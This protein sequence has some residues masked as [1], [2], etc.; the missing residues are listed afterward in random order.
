[1]DG[2]CH[3]TQLELVANNIIR[4]APYDPLLSP[5]TQIANVMDQQSFYSRLTLLL[6]VWT[7]MFGVPRTPI[8]K[9]PYKIAYESSIA[10]LHTLQT[11]VL[12]GHVPAVAGAV[13]ASDF[14]LRPNN[15]QKITL[16][17]GEGDVKLSWW[18]PLVE[19]QVAQTMP[20][21]TPQAKA[22]MIRGS[23]GPKVL[24]HMANQL[25]YD[26]VF[27]SNPARICNFV[28]SRT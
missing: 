10:M 24:G 16:Y 25:I 26:S 5:S 9:A 8:E 6:D 1:M 14:V 12:S 18:R 23:L 17:D 20:N 28:L 2:M 19:E 4:P 7:D 22:H 11:S 13:R 27:W 21:A 3:L 15:F